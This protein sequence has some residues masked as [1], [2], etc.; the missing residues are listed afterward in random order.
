M[1]QN[2]LLSDYLLG[3]VELTCGV[4][5]SFP[6]STSCWSDLSHWAGDLALWGVG[7]SKA[8]GPCREE[9]MWRILQCSQSQPAET[10]ACCLLEP[11]ETLLSHSDHYLSFFLYI[12]STILVLHGWCSLRCTGLSIR[13][14][15]SLQ[16]K[17]YGLETWK[18]KRHV[19]S[20]NWKLIHNPM[21]YQ[22]QKN[23]V[24]KRESYEV[25]GE[26][27]KL[28]GFWGSAKGMWGKG[29]KRK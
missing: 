4:T 29:G 14:V 11:L 19:L 12:S 18:W 6:G 21:Y 16:Q 5:F 28:F 27:V 13:L 8:Q 24:L 10:A 2:S 26:Q 3:D 9:V 23:V 7:V 25:E 15:L 17:I 1:E 22:R 20:L